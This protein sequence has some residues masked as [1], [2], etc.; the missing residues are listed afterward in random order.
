VKLEYSETW[1]G[2]VTALD[3][4]RE[5]VGIRIWKSSIPS[6]SLKKGFCLGTY[7]KSKGGG[8]TDTRLFISAR[9]FSVLANAMIAADPKR[10]AA[11]FNEA[12]NV[13]PNM[14]S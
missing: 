7:L 8:T 14:A 4:K 6:W 12:M 11:A 1:R 9:D 10:A 2:G 3:L 13:R 5:S